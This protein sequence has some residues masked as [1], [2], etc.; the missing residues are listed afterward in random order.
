VWK[1][2]DAVRIFRFTFCSL[3]AKSK[4]RNGQR[5]T[6]RNRQMTIAQLKANMIAA[7]WNHI[8]STTRTP[9]HGTNY[10][11]LFTKDGQKFYLNNE[12]R[13]NLPA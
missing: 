4:H 13:D 11:L 5:P 7:G 12:T 9:G 10:G 3:F 2:S 6:A 8:L 1:K